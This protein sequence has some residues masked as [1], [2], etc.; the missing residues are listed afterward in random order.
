MKVNIDINKILCRLPVMDK[1]KVAFGVAAS[2]LFLAANSIAP[3]TKKDTKLRHVFVPGS[4]EPRPEAYIV[5]APSLM[6]LLQNPS[7][8]N[9]NYPILPLPVQLKE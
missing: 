5:P 9:L 7:G 4:F 8:F 3:H 6:E 1:N 2:A